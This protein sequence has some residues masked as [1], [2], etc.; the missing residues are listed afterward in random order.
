MVFVPC[1]VMRW[2]LC[3]PTYSVSCWGINVNSNFAAKNLKNVN[4]CVCTCFIYNCYSIFM[5]SYITLYV[6][7]KSNLKNL[8]EEWL[9]LYEGVI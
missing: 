9:L 4:V 8:L 3:V 1:T 7:S 5:N 6:F 2:R